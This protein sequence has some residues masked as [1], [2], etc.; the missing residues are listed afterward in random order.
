MLKRILAVVAGLV[1]GVIVVM[2]G[3][4]T[5]HILFPIP[6][7][8]DLSKKEAIAQ[9]MAMIPT[10]ALVI[11]LFFWLLSSF[12]GAFVAT[13]INKPGRSIAPTISPSTCTCAE[14]TR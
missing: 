11:M 14:L 5:T 12:L 1:T 2:V 13:K 9:L 3:D 7:G 10:T 6:E 8:I 4:M